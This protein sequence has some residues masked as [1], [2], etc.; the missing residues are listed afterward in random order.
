MQQWTAQKEK[1]S[2]LIVSKRDEKMEAE[3]TAKAARLHEGFVKAETKVGDQM[4][5]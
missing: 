1:I 5:L 2:E 4:I 3:K